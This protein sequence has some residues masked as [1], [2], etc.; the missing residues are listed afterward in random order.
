MK[1]DEYQKLAQRTSNT[2]LN[3]SSQINGLLGL[4]GEVGEVTDIFKKHLF[5]GHNL[6][7][8]E[9]IEEMGDVLWYMAE[10]CTG[11]NIS[12]EQVA[13]SNIEK[14]KRRYPDGF[15]SKKSIRRDD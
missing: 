1:F 5:Q 7:R 13:I 6:N 3:T 11:L 15:E 4:N 2:N 9:V 12:M 8:E 10:L 14:L